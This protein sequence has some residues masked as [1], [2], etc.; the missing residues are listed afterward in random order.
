MTN[1]SSIEGGRTLWCPVKHSIITSKLNLAFKEYNNLII[2]INFFE[3]KKKP[4]EDNLS[5]IQLNSTSKSLKKIKYEII[6]IIQFK[7]LKITPRSKDTIFRKGWWKNGNK[8]S[9]RTQQTCWALE[10]YSKCIKK[11]L[12]LHLNLYTYII[13]SREDKPE[14][15]FCRF[16]R[17]IQRSTCLSLQSSCLASPR[18][19]FWSFKSPFGF[20][21][22]SSSIKG[23]GTIGF[24]LGLS[25]FLIPKGIKM[26]L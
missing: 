21:F 24:L 25:P 6:K 8:F 22:N 17:R 13:V 12:I 10:K 16:L 3:L 26:D 9:S 1:S 5:S 11:N 18:I 20:F 14:C 19:C 4:G 23:T 15:L 7:I 2:I